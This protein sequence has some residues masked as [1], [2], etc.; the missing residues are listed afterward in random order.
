MESMYSPE[1]TTSDGY[2][3]PD[4]L[5]GLDETDIVKIS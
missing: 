3:I 5:R 4:F 1:E 2:E